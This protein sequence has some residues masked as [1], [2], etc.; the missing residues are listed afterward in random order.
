[1]KKTIIG[2]ILL[3]LLVSNVSAKGLNPR[4]FKF[5][6]KDIGIA[7]K[8]PEGWKIFT[9][10]ENAPD[11]FKALLENR[12]SK[13][14]SPL[15]LGMKK[16][17]NGFSRLTVEKY[18]ASLDEYINLFEVML[19][20][21]NVKVISKTYSEDKNNVT[22]IYNSKVNNIPIRF[23][24]YIVVNNE[25]AL[26]LSFWSLDSMFD[27]QVNEFTEI[28]HEALFYVK[29][30]RNSW[31]PLWANVKIS[32]EPETPVTQNNYK[33]MFFTVKS[34]TNTVYLMGSIHVGKDSFYPFPERIEKAFS[35]TN[36]I[37]VEYNANSKENEGKIRNISSYGYLDDNKTLK[38][39]LSKDLYK[40]LETNLSNYN[41]PIDKMARFKP[42]IVAA[43]LESLKMMS[44][45]YVMDSGTEKYF[46][47]KAHDKKV[48]ELESFDQQAKIFDSIDGNLFL[49]MTLL[50]LSSTEK[51]MDIIIDS[52]KNQDM[53]KMEELTMEGIENANQKDYFD[54][55]Y[56]NRNI[57]MTEKIKGYLGQ[58]ENY[59]V[60][61]GSGHLVG[62][63]GILALLK[64]AGY[65]VE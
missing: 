42:W 18:E 54:K 65:N 17:Q 3:L 5:Y 57:T 60:I 15:F 40:A 53:K 64:K 47:N 21:S 24:D 12:K 7:I 31:V 25:Y 43:S 22:V 51:E 38:D 59:F 55:L 39:I 13:N 41:I 63:R 23:V 26:R 58:A 10:G 33:Y 34:K 37:V 6:N 35:N 29:S 14:D 4:D 45:G 62:D 1:M 30:D 49:T 19:N 48:F 56:F 16:N 50:S 52:W 44:L 2:I 27:N 9:D 20:I 32:N 36:N 61:V 46:L 8:F 11:S 28:A